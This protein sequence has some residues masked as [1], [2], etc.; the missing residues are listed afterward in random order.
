MDHKRVA[1]ITGAGSGLGRGLAI[2]LSR[3]GYD[4]IL[5]GR[6]EERLRLVAEECNCYSIARY[7]CFDITDDSARS[8][9][10]EQINHLDLSQTLLINN[11]AIMYD[12]EF[13]DIS[14]YD[15]RYA[16][17]VNMVA[18]VE[19][20]REFYLRLKTVNGVIYI[21]SN[22]ACY[23]Q[24]YNSIYSASKAG[25]RYLLEALRIEVDDKIRI[26][27]AYPPLM[28]TRMIQKFDSG[29]FKL[30]KTDPMYVAEQIVSAY[31]AGRDEISW[32]DAETLVG[33][34]YRFAPHLFQGILGRYR[35]M[36]RKLIVGR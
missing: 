17:C 15:M 25:L 27:L 12:G 29:R 3:R 35:L 14:T 22:S 1:I 28:D 32:L 18:P 6:N 2:T 21:L 9:F 10:W 23:P 4:V 31:E 7:F 11:A 24:P 33:M 26:F 34:L 5:I 20:T 13:F 16:F 30:K 36:L 8:L 19:F